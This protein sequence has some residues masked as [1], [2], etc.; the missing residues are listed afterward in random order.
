MNE[1]RYPAAQSFNG[2]PSHHDTNI[3]VLHMLQCSAMQIMRLKTSH[4]ELVS[5]KPDVISCRG[6]GPGSHRH[7]LVQLHGSAI[8]E[9]RPQP[10]GALLNGRNRPTCP[11]LLEKFTKARIIDCRRRISGRPK[12]FVCND[13]KE[14]AMFLSGE[15]WADLTPEKTSAVHTSCLTIVPSLKA[16]RLDAAGDY[17]RRG[18]VSGYVMPCKGYLCLRPWLFWLLAAMAVMPA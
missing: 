7:S 4:T 6:S 1:P 12:G 10:H 18:Y 2:V 13:D 11:R 9:H 8:E 14:H 3:H 15:E 5:L 17:G 16:M